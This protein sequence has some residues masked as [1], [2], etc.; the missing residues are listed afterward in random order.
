MYLITLHQRTIAMVINFRVLA[1]VVAFAGIGRLQA[2]PFNTLFTS[3]SDLPVDTLVARE[4]AT[5]DPRMKVALLARLVRQY[6]YLDR[7]D[8]VHVDLERL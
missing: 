2:Q 3:I 7:Q 5:D 4:K 6:L 1:L 8:Q